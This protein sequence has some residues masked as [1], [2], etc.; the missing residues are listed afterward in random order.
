MKEHAQMLEPDS[1][2]AG[3]LCFLK[4]LPSLIIGASQDK[5]IINAPSFLSTLAKLP[6]VFECLYCLQI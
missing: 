6:A 4:N 2:Q 1:C 3:D 5:A